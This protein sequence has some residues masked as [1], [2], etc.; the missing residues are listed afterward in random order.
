[1]MAFTARGEIFV[2]D[3]ESDELLRVTEESGARSRSATFLNEE[4]LVV[5]TDEGGEQQIALRYFGGP[6]E[7]EIITEER[8]AWFFPR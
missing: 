2:I 8:H 4:T 1:M 6:P 7:Q 5:I 3:F